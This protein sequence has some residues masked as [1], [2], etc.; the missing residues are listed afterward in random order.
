MNIMETYA[1]RKYSVIVTW[2]K[3]GIGNGK[4][5]MD[6]GSEEMHIQKWVT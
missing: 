1:K 6:Y 2:H 4:K 3:S 5:E